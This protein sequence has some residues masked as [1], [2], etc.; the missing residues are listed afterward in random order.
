MQKLIKKLSVLTAVLGV[1]VVM[2]GC[3][4]PEKQEDNKETKN[5]EYAHPYHDGEAHKL[6]GTKVITAKMYQKNGEGERMGDIKFT[7]T[8]E[9]LK[10]AL[11]L[12]H[13]RPGA[14]YALHIY[15][16]KECSTEDGEQLDAKHTKEQKD[17]DLP[18]VKGDKDGKIKGDYI[19]KHLSA[20][21]MKN[22]KISLVRAGEDGKKVKVGWGKI[23]DE[24]KDM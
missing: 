7:D 17:V 11:D 15:K 4:G 19:I 13:V 24:K 21:D 5:V 22:T 23:K 14:E 18:K 3:S 16:V 10:M 6:K 9:G 2:A 20:S 12:K 8:D 1:A